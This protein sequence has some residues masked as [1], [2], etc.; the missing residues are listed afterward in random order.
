MMSSHFRIGIYDL[1]TRSFR[2][3][4]ISCLTA[5]EMT[6]DSEGKEIHAV[7]RVFQSDNKEDFRK[8]IESSD[9]VVT[10][11]GDSFDNRV[12][13]ECW[14]VVV[15][16]HKSYDLMKE[17]QKISGQ[18]VKLADLAL[19]NV[20]LTKR[21][22][23]G[24]S[25]PKLWQERQYGRLID[26]GLTDAWISYL[27]FKLVL[28]G[29]KLVDPYTGGNSVKLPSPLGYLKKVVEIGEIKKQRTDRIESATAKFAAKYAEVQQLKA[30]R[31]GMKY[32]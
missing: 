11:N 8:L 1:E 9:L 27:L 25:A 31:G 4:G 30:A 5:V 3:D 17:Y 6:V 20:G 12:V 16:R 2:N 13:E 21:D 15:P 26:Y 23:D 18:R 10:F 19:R 14:E 28:D 32:V 29:K 7:P 24:A 22:K